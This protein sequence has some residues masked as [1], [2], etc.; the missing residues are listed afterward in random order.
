M[1]AAFAY[2]L[3]NEFVS[4]HTHKR[5]DVHQA[6]FPKQLNFLQDPAKKKAIICPRRSAKSYSIGLHLIQDALDTPDV[7]CGVIA[8]TRQSVELMYWRDIFLHIL[9]RFKIPYKANLTKLTITLRNGSTI[10][11]AGADAKADEMEKFLGQK[12]KTIAV[13]EASMWRQSVRKLVYDILDPATTDLDGTI[14]MAGTPSNYTTDIFYDI[15]KDS[16][17]KFVGEWSVHFW[18]PADNP[19]V[20]KNHAKKMA[21][22]IKDNPGIELTPGFQQMWLGQWI[23][24]LSAICYKYSPYKNLTKQMPHGKYHRVLGIDL[25]YDDD[26][27]MVALA[28]SFTQRKTYFTN[29]FK[30]KGM[31]IDDVKNMIE[32]AIKHFDPD[33]IVIDGA[34]KQT[35]ETLK[36]RYGLPLIKADKQGKSEHIDLLSSQLQIGEAMVLEG[37]GNVLFTFETHGGEVVDV[38]D[39]C[40]P[41]VEEW[42]GLIWDP[43]KL[44]EGIRQEHPSLP[45]HCADAGL[46]GWR[47]THAYAAEE[48]EVEEQENADEIDEFWERESARLTDPEGFREMQELGFDQQSNW[49]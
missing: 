20:A 6:A 32:K 40:E 1:D 15:T 19:H 7:T 4:R 23:K 10:A 27:S 49:E 36:Q 11:L 26:T 17:T 39:T 44:E 38:M 22:L 21:Q 28:Y 29:A 31:I 37:S 14:I 47:Y 30:K 35:V 9:R 46:Y 2:D 8:K 16:E 18:T 48:P 41:I 25:G 34:S 43:K 3:V 5:V 13:E 42:E 24:D 12:F 45:N 33:T